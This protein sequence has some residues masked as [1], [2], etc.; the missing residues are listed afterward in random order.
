MSP[1]ATRITVSSNCQTGG[2]A[3]GLRDLLPRAEIEPLPVS[4]IRAYKTPERVLRDLENADVWVYTSAHEVIDLETLRRARPGLRIVRIP[5]IRFY[6]F[7]PD[8]CYARHGST[9]ELTQ[10]HYNSS[11]AGWA[12]NHALSVAD[13]RRLFAADVYAE[14]GFFDRWR[15]DVAALGQEFAESDLDFRPFYLAVKRQGVFMHTPNHPKPGA[16]VALA[17]LV[18]V[19]VTGDVSLLG[20]P[21]SIGDDLLGYAW[22][23][24]PEIARS[25]VLEPGSLD[26][27]MDGRWLLGL[28]AFLDAAFER[29]ARQGIRPGDLRFVPGPDEAHYDRVLGPRIGRRP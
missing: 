8:V 20:R 11:I 19:A 26:W 2:L 4:T 3:A 5:R 6:A 23:V 1:R 9:G 22:P 17:R 14:L 29:Y 12:Y 24:Y 10:P 27:K 13:A 28:D 7:H 25:L 18:A 21:L 15:H 16:I